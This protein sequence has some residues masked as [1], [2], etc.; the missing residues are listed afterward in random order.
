[1]TTENQQLTAEQIQDVIKTAELQTYE[2]IM[3][4]PEQ[5]LE[6]LHSAYTRVK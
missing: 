3:R 4:T 6:A 1:M 2:I 5:A